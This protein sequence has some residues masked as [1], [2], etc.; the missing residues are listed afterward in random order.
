MKSDAVFKRAFNDAV[1]FVSALKTGDALPT[2]VVLSSQLGVSRTTVRKVL[3]ELTSRGV[4]TGSGQHRTLRRRASA[5][6]F[7]EQETVSA[8][9][10]VE[11]RF[12]EWMLRDDS[13]P[14][15]VINELVIESCELVLG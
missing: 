8:A 14:G 3:S 2:E 15:V 7:P 12:M 9:T 4:I 11:R 6:R 5:K 1:D 10:Q 13:R